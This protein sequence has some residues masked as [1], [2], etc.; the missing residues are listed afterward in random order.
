MAR[1]RRVS[2]VWTRESKDEPPALSPGQ[3]VT[4][5]I[6]L[7]DEEGLEALSMRRLGA[8]LNAGA[9]SLYRH[10]SNRNELIELIVDEVYQEIE[11]PEP[12]TPE[13]WRASV[14]VC[15][16]SMRSM[17][18]RHP[19]IAP[20]LGM[21]GL[22]YLGPNVLRLNER[23]QQRFEAVGF[24]PREAAHAIS[25]LVSYVIGM[26]VSEAAWLT[27]VARTGET[28]SAVH[29]S[30]RPAIERA[31]RTHLDEPARFLGSQVRD[32]KRNRDEKFEY[33]LDRLLDGFAAR[34]G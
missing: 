1:A 33:G 20:L 23:M 34:L 24:E 7:L 15:A 8:R 9:T 31:V 16:H 12:D 26:G 10:V 18:L 30:L 4:E 19:W 11:V 3:I 5:A 32:P 25:A 29:A 13:D 21:T 14:A 17:I 6:R 2:S 27:L 22:S 28:E